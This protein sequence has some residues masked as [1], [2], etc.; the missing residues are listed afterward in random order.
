MLVAANYEPGLMHT[1]LDG[2]I[3]RLVHAGTTGCVY[4]Q[5]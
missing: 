1:K 3:Q 2:N 4:Y 5:Q